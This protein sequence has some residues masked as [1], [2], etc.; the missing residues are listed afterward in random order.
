MFVVLS[1]GMLTGLT[2]TMMAQAVPVFADKKKCE[3][4]D[5][6][7]CNDTH[8]TQK[9]DEKNKCKIENENKDHSKKN[10]NEN[11]LE[12][13]NFAANVKDLLVL[14]QR[15]DG[16]DQQGSQSTQAQQ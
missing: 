8:K 15:V 13:S 12:C 1:A 2:A 5:N 9:I 3:D 7:N 6:N 14:S 10:D 16:T 11:L 4:N